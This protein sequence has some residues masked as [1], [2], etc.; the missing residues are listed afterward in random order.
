MC[1]LRHTKLL[2]FLVELAVDSGGVG[3]IPTITVEDV[4]KE[5]PMDAPQ[6]PGR[7]PA[8][9]APPIPDW[10]K[11]GWRAFTDIDKPLEDDDQRQL[12]LMNTWIS[13]QYYGQWY[14]NAGII[15]FVC[16][17]TPCLIAACSCS[18]PSPCSYNKQ[19]CICG[20]LCGTLQPWLWLALHYPGLVQYI[21]HD[22]HGSC[23]TPC[24][25]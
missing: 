1:F 19:G 11:V 7:L 3:P 8:S 15:S 5:V 18:Y 23:T 24:T 16:H 22:F 21:L 17:P 12:R 4:D 14:Q 9:K 25:R 20:T 10:Y 6:I 13:E 2:L